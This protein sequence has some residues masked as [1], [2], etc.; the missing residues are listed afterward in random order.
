[1]NHDDLAAQKHYTP[2]GAYGQSKLANILFARK[3]AERLPAGQTAVSLHPGVIDT[4]LSRHLN[5]AA[6]A[7]FSVVGRLFLKSI[8]QGAA[9]QCFVAAHP[10]GTADNGAYFADCNVAKPS[11][12]G[13][14]D[15]LADRL[16]TET[17][18]IVAG[19]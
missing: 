12:L 3:L 16:W 7:V 11:R 1:M 13:R 2:W 4:N 19:L 8:P 5:R 18:A 6:V 14:D 17:E 10:D 9:T 15:A